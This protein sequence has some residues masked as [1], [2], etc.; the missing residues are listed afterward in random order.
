MRPLNRIQPL[1]GAMAYR[2]FAITQPLATHFRPA[3]CAEAECLAYLKGWATAIDEG[4]ELGQ[5]Q[6]F[7]IRKVSGRKFTEERTETGLTRFTFEA[8]QQ[9][10]SSDTHRIPLERPVNHFTWGGDWRVQPKRHDV[11]TLRGDDWQDMFANHQDK[12]K[13]TLERG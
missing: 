6:A 13:T 4:T 10:F 1:M 12:L 11:R 2:T 3:T 9:C 8:G 7:Y 5:Q